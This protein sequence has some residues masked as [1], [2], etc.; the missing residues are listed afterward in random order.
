MED[1][2]NDLLE[3]ANHDC[4]DVICYDDEYGDDFSDI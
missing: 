1:Y 4:D 2:T 3:E